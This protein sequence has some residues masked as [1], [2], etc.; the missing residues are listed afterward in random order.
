M[1]SV[2]TSFPADRPP[3]WT[4]IAGPPVIASLVPPNPWPASRLKLIVAFAVGC[5]ST[6][7]ARPTPAG[8]VAGGV[9]ARWVSPRAA[10]TDATCLALPAE[11]QVSVPNGSDWDPES[12]SRPPPEPT[13]E[14]TPRMFAI[15]RTSAWLIL[16]GA[17]LAGAKTVVS[18]AAAA[19]PPATRPAVTIVPV[20]T[21]TFSI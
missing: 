17:T 11:D 8:S 3:Y 14:S 2:V 4:S 5:T 19:T 7:A 12:G 21:E 18:V 16:T 9:K 20:P 13:P 15:A 6:V 10:A 1:P